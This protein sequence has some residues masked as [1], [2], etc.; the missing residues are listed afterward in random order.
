MK[1]FITDAETKNGLLY[2]PMQ[3]EGVERENLGKCLRGVS[4]IAY[5]LPVG[6]SLECAWLLRLLLDT[7]GALE[8]SSAT[9][10]V[11]GWEEA[12]SLNIRLLGASEMDEDLF[13]RSAVD[14]FQIDEIECLVYEDANIHTECGMALRSLAKEEL[15]IAAST[16]PG[17]VSMKAPF[18]AGEFRP[19][20]PVSEYRAERL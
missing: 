18:S 10:V 3:Y 12:G 15:V 11:S 7:G 8:F 19:E 1:P 4:I 17:S 20:F 13:V 5:A 16:P 6:H 14:R 9:T 2:L